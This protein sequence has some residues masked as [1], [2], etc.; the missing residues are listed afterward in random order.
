MRSGRGTTRALAALLLLLLA[1]ACGGGTGGTPVAPPA[2]SAPAPAP[3][4]EL[5]VC[6]DERELALEYLAHSGPNLPP[7]LVEFWDGT[8]IRV[9][10]DETRIPEAERPHAEH[11]LAVV[12]RFSERIENQLGYPILE[13]GGWIG[14]DDG[15]VIEMDEHLSIVRC[16]TLEPG[17]RAVITATPEFASV[18]AAFPACAL[19]WFQTFDL[20]AD[21][22]APH[23][24]FHLFGFRHSE[25]THPEE[26]EWGG[27]PMSRGLTTGV[28]AAG[29]DFIEGLGVA[30][31]DID[32]L[33]CVLPEGG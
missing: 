23:E 31:E 28:N 10:L 29:T 26:R 21:Y 9:D 12:G 11:M 13:P 18:G 20:P 2:V 6:T 24:L 7:Q 22:L 16:A 15:F 25:E 27:I 30:F 33:R 8:P 4:P 1:A 3:P 17:R 14:E 32:A 19:A 5:R